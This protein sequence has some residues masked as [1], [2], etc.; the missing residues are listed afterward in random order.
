[1]SRRRFTGEDVASVLIDMDYYP[2]D[3]TGSHLKLRYQH[4]KTGEVRNVTVPMGGE[5]QTGTLRNIA[6]QCGA[7]DFEAF[8]E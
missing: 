3:R 5:I 4:P 6:D 1:M 8:C 7:Q 2:V